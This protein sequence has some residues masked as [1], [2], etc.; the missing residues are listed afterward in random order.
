M[1]ENL[2]EHIYSSVGEEFL[3]SQSKGEALLQ[4]ASYLHSFGAE[5]SPAADATKAFHARLV[6][7]RA[8]YEAMQEELNQLIEPLQ[9]VW[10]AATGCH[11]GN[12]YWTDS[13]VKAALHIFSEEKNCA[14]A[15]ENAKAD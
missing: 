1:S 14:S 11:T 8:Q 13:R 7:L 10:L 5:G 2:F 9:P 6:E 3:T 4:M 15:V 12:A